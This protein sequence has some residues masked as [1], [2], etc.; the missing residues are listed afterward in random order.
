VG[1]E[2]SG[3]EARA[4][5]SNNGGFTSDS[6][7]C[8]NSRG[9]FWGY[10]AAL[11]QPNG[12]FRSSEIHTYQLRKKGKSMRMFSGANNRLGCR[13]GK[14]FIVALGGIFA[15]SV[16]LALPSDAMANGKPFQELA[17][18][19]DRL[20]AQVRM[21]N[22]EIESLA[23]D[24]EA[25]ETAIADLETTVSTKCE[26]IAAL[27]SDVVDLLAKDEE[28]IAAIESA[29]G[30]TQEELIVLLADPLFLQ[31]AFLTEE[32]AA[33]HDTLSEDLAADVAALSDIIEPVADCLLDIENCVLDIIAP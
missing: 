25:A 14:T 4:H 30:L 17:N 15:M 3:S 6:V 8:D 7:Q 32:F 12:G 22:A 10:L 11:M 18:R 23:E 26:E 21:Q 16:F 19:I 29:D 31:M 9:E 20:Q 24:L 13:A 33:I 28:L 27:Q 2:I 1:P 5:R